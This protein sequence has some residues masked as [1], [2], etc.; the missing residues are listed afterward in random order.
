MC[1]AEP[2]C[3]AFVDNHGRSPAYC[4][5][6]KSTDTYAKSTKDT[7]IKPRTKDA[8]CTSASPCGLGEGDS[9]S[10]DECAGSLHCFQR[11]AGDPLPGSALA[12]KIT[13]RAQPII[14][15]TPVQ[16]SIMRTGVTISQMAA[17]ETTVVTLDRVIATTITTVKW[18][19][20]RAARCGPRMP[21]GV[22][23]SRVAFDWERRLLLRPRRNKIMAT[24][25]CRS[26]HAGIPQAAQKRV[27]GSWRR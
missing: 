2:A 14:A 22:V 5:F 7:Y 18:P 8:T 20:V 4:V 3:E 10:D 9:N 6:K 21:P 17:A 24:I 27:K 15:L 12:P 11:G 1:D 16:V 26:Y 13:L 19:Q 25:K 23:A